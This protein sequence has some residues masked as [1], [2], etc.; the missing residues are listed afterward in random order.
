MAK[1]ASH[2]PASRIL[3]DEHFESGDDRFLD[4]VLACTDDAALKRLAPKWYRDSRPWARKALLAYVDDG[5]D[6]PR[7][8]VLVKALL[9]LAERNDDDE[10]MA[11]FLRAFDGLVRHEVTARTYF[12]WS[13][14][15]QR[16]YTR[17]AQ[18]KPRSRP[19]TELFEHWRPKGDFRFAAPLFSTP[20]RSYLRRRAYRWFRRLGRRDPARFFAGV[21][22]ALGLYRDADL[23]RPEHVLDAYG[24]TNLLYYHS[25]ALVRDTRRLRV[26]EGRTLAELEP[27]PLYPDAW[28]G[29]AEPLLSL[30]AR[31]DCV[32]V[33][34]FLVRWL[35]REE[36]DALRGIDARR[37][38]PLLASP[39]GDVRAFA[40]RLLERASGL[41]TLP[42]AD[43]LELL[44]LDDVELLPIV[45]RLVR[46]H[47]D[48]ARL[49]RAQCV[50]LAVAPAAPVAELGFSW[51]KDKPVPDAAALSEVLAV[52]AAEVP[53]VRA[54]AVRWLLERVCGELGT[55]EHL[56]ELIDAR[57]ADVRAEALAAMRREPRFADSPALWMAL[58]ESPY[59]DVLS[60]L[61]AHL[62]EREKALG[63]GRV[64]R[65]WATTLLSVHRGSRAKRAALRQ[66]A[67]R[68]VRW[69][70]RADA[71][72]PILR[73]A[74]RSVREAERRAALAAVSRAAFENEA[75]RASIAR[76]V[77]EL[78]LFP[79]E[80]ARA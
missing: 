25:D 28:R 72:L 33:R 46:E 63:A 24:L 50:K 53:H 15:A 80:G 73:V 55:V 31:S 16:R 4:E 54:E 23:A 19:T 18:V 65:V 17:L 64:E 10:L 42:I 8:R 43:W 62:D 71:L 13:S 9:N 27:A 69:P 5:C 45:C 41:G 30:L 14:G 60:A 1:E 36:E 59:P 44:E 12:D 3:L 79:S 26:A 35:E 37:L 49:D 22:L 58:A 21:T 40:V 52:A 38:K 76:H 6:R 70:E 56:R 48:P 2:K 78:T 39:H 57:H 51:L 68:I 47:V 75:L 11:H 7:H 32:Y 66:I 61:L 67:D 74:L 34:R 29:Q 77:P 20:T